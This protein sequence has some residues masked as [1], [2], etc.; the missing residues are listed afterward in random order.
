MPSK[1]INITKLCIAI[2]LRWLVQYAFTDTASCPTACTELDMRPHDLRGLATTLKSFT[3]V[4]MSDLL[5]A[6][7][8]TSMSSF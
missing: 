4:T 7:V 3:H 6:N 1:Q 2:Y 5:A 8:W